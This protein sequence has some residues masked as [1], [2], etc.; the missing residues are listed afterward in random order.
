MFTAAL[1]IRAQRLK[2]L[3][4]LSI[5]EWINE[6]WYIHTIEYYL[7]IRRNEA[8]THATT[9]VSPKD[10]MLSETSQIQKTTYY[11]IP[12]TCNVQNREIHRDINQLRDC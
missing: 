4:C 9:W 12:P 8:L 2:Q 5:D 10:I 1:C 6:M 7:A 3:K 11:M